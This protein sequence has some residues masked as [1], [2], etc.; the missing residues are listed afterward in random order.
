MSICDSPY[1]IPA[2]DINECVGTSLVTINGNFKDLRDDACDTYQTLASIQSD[3]IQL[4]SLTN[5]ISSLSPGIPKALVAFNGY[6][7]PPTIYTSYNVKEVK[8]L[9]TGT[10]S[11]SFTTALANTNGAIIGTCIETVSGGSYTWLQPT[12]FTTVSAG[13]NIH[14]FNNTT[15]A[16]PSYISVIIYNK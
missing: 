3:F 16:D 14:S 7:T 1:T 5:T 10:F 13:I 8:K 15:S 4:S 6:A 9:S 2:I 12:S 11:L